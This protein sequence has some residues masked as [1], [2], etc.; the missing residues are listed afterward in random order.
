M[1]KL[2]APFLALVTGIGLGILLAKSMTPTHSGHDTRSGSADGGE[3]S[4]LR[5]RPAS[6]TP[7]AGKATT[8]RSASSPRSLAAL[9]ELAG[10]PGDTQDSITFL[11]AVEA[12]GVE[13]IAA[14]MSDLEKMDPNDSRRYRLCVALMNRW[15]LIDPDGAWDAAVHFKSRNLRQQLVSSVIGAISR[16]D[17]G[18]ARLLLSEIK[19]PQTRQ[20]ALYAF[21]NQAASEDPEE[22]FRVLAS[23][24][25][26]SGSYGYYHTLFAK[27]AKED[28]DAAIAKL[29]Q[30][31]NTKDRQQAQHG[32]AVA[33]VISDPQRALEMLA[34]MPPG[35]SRVSMI[36]SISSAWM[37]HDKD[38]AMAWINGL[39]ATDRS[40][41]L[42][43]V[44]WQLGQEDPAKAAELL[45]SLPISSQTSHQFSQLA[46]QWAQQD[47]AAARKWVESL[48][49]GRTR[50]QAKTG[51]ISTL[52]QHDPAK[53]ASML[54]GAA[55]TNQNSHQVGTIVGDWIK[56]DQTAALA[57][58]NSLDLRGDAQRNVHSQFL[59]N[60][61]NEDAPA[62][63]R[64][65][66]G[67][68]DESVRQQAISSLVGA[69]GRNNPQAAREWITTS[70]EG[71]SKNTALKSLIQNL[72]HQDHTTALRYYQEATAG[73]SPEAVE[74]NF[75]STA[76]QIARNWIQHEPKAA[77]QWVMTLPEGESRA[78]SVRSL[79]DD[80]G[81]YDIKGA[82]EFVNTLAVGKER[83][84]AV[85]SLVS[86]LG[87][88]G[89][90]QSAFDWAASISD[91]SRRE[92]A[93]RTAANQ[94]KDYDPSAA[95][96][97]V[98]GADISSEA[99]D[100][101][102]KGLEN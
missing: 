71:D 19:D 29:S 5:T 58:L 12:L 4:N 28:P 91:V 18:K 90:P 16:S 20:N 56:T 47:L 31:Q 33:L 36:G 39:P 43:N 37:G 14:L 21:L 59:N 67:I 17:L 92:S 70:L 54:D 85:A 24:S 6:R 95:R 80:L 45:S 53:A 72:S 44:T 64:Y 60:W 65:A 93:I 8:G 7:S 68:Q 52:T 81:D 48:P 99:R 51:I 89:D 13:E 42:Q 10:D 77:G 34:D 82:A 49:A 57:W 38:A 88:Q 102:L 2:T 76:S 32:I 78:N 46:G 73:L 97:A 55:V 50:E 74:K 100:K 23:E 96:A 15:A 35:Q 61:V 30:I 11:E 94:W 41:A 26:G 63:S 40:R 66:L 83:D 27:W 75:G 22:A 87:N 69:W 9:M 86:D 1:R 98:N 79:V 101:I 62:A 3:S 84:Q 25:A